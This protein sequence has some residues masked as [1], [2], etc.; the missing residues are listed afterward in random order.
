MMRPG[1]G[2][3][4]IRNFLTLFLSIELSKAMVDLTAAADA[5]N[6]QMATLAQQRISLFEHQLEESNPILTA[7][8]EA[9]TQEGLA[10]EDLAAAESDAD[11][12]RLTAR[13]AKY[14]ALKEGGNTLLQGVS[15]RHA[16]EMMRLR[17]EVA[18]LSSK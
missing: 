16:A 6:T 9:M 8:S 1:C 18:A 15:E 13:V 2:G 7:I 17:K 11:K 3:F 14:R 4:G 10:L 12:A 5:G